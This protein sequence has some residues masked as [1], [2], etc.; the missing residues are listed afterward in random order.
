MLRDQVVKL[1]ISYDDLLKMT[2]QLTY[3]SVIPFN[4]YGVI[5]PLYLDPRFEIPVNKINYIEYF[6]KEKCIKFTFNANPD[7]IFD[8]D[9]YHEIRLVDS[10]SDK[11][12]QD[13][14]AKVSSVLTED[15]NFYYKQVD[16]DQPPV[17]RIVVCAANKFTIVGRDIII[18]SARHWDRIMCDI[19]DL[20]GMDKISRENN[21]KIRESQVQG[22]ID[23]FGDFL[24]R[25]EALRIASHAKQLNRYCH[26]HPSYDELYSEDLY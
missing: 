19:A 5:N 23:Q 4:D 7:E 25:E 16:A 9:E 8:R 10:T 14:V 21:Q 22:F 6:E 15:Q 1:F 3:R 17:M 13:F 26:K 20:I 2:P 12:C 18:P 11:I 24:T